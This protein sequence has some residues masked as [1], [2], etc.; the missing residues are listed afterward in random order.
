[1]LSLTNARGWP[2]KVASTK[3]LFPKSFS[4]T[5]S[6]SKIVN[7]PTLTDILIT[8]LRDNLIVEITYPGK[9]KFFNVSVPTALALI[10]N[11]FDFIRDL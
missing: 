8:S 9:I 5:T 2:M 7:F 6:L 3:K 4:F 11:M 1:M 10:N